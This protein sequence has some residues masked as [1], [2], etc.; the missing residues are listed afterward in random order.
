[1]Q[2][3]NATYHTKNYDFISL[4]EWIDF[5]YEAYLFLKQKE[6]LEG[7]RSGFKESDKKYKTIMDNMQT[8]TSE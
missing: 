7:K 6:D 8:V 1:M 4:L 2:I 3:K 5:N